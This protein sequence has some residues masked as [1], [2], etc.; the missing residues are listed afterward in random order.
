MDEHGIALRVYTNSIVI[1]D[2]SKRRSYV[3]SLEDREWVSIIETVLGTGEFIRP[4]V[5]F[6]GLAP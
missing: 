3:K 1:G 5:I 6:K 2:A 4:L